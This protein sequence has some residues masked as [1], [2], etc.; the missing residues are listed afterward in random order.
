[1]KVAGSHAGLTC[2]GR[3]PRRPNIGDLLG[4][5]V[6]SE[7]MKCGVMITCTWA[8]AGSDFKCSVSAASSEGGRNDDVSMTSGSCRP[9]QRMAPSVEAT[10][11]TRP[12]TCASSSSRR[13][14]DRMGSGSMA[15]IRPVKTFFDVATELCSYVCG[16]CPDPSSA[17][18]GP[19]H[20]G[21]ERLPFEH[22][23]RA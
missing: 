10:T 7:S 21:P 12:S 8:A 6:S 15:R 23:C 14:R 18:P 20:S 9:M 4:R 17:I 3:R 19:A 2:D 16:C 22:Q 11:S 13:F 5:A 1:M